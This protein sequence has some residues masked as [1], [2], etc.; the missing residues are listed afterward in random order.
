MAEKNA[1]ISPEE[2]LVVDMTALTVGA[3]V[4]SDGAKFSKSSKRYVRDGKRSLAL[5]EGINAIQPAML[6]RIR[7]AYAKA[8]EKMKREIETGLQEYYETT[9]EFGP[10]GSVF[11]DKSAFGGVYNGVKS[12]VTYAELE[13]AKAGKANVATAEIKPDVNYRKGADFLFRKYGVMLNG[14]IGKGK[15]FSNEAEAKD[16]IY[17]Y[18]KDYGI[19]KD[20]EFMGSLNGDVKNI[21]YRKGS[22]VLYRKYNWFHGDISRD[23]YYDFIRAN[24]IDSPNEFMKRIGNDEKNIPAVVGAKEAGAPVRAP[25]AAVGI[26]EDQRIMLHLA[27]VLGEN[28][29]AGEKTFYKDIYKNFVVRGLGARNLEILRSEF[30]GGEERKALYEFLYMNGAGT[31]AYEK[32]KVIL[33]GK[34]PA[35]TLMETVSLYG[36]KVRQTM[37]RYGAAYLAGAETRKRGIVPTLKAPSKAANE[38]GEGATMDG[39]R[40]NI[41]FSKALVQKRSVL[42]LIMPWAKP[43]RNSMEIVLDAM[44]SEKGQ[45]E[46]LSSDTNKVYEFT[47]GKNTLYVDI[48]SSGT[49]GKNVDVTITLRPNRHDVKAEEM[50]RASFTVG[51]DGSIGPEGLSRLKKMGIRFFG[52]RNEDGKYTAKYATSVYYA[53][54]VGTEMAKERAN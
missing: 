10:F 48:N 7:S 44:P 9:V 37:G 25:G 47:L 41:D 3:D 21:R 2:Q 24:R 6:K 51:P 22:Y 11:V 5:E 12:K 54:K 15:D 4:L 28:I 52:I 40:I 33:S 13:T 36:G 38:I 1:R 43:N 42:H 26:P 46:L 39:T 32:L 35:T 29:S 53:K 31:A 49:M 14:F 34:E 8:S 45:S 16:F 50:R 30:K 18:I 23:D 19:T 20:S 17:T 27:A